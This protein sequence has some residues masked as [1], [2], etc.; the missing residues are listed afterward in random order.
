MTEQHIKRVISDINYLFSFSFTKMS[1]LICNNE[2]KTTFYQ[3]APIA[4]QLQAK[5]ETNQKKVIIQMQTALEEERVNVE[6]LQ[7]ALE[8]ERA[9]VQMLQTALEAEHSKNIQLQSIILADCELINE[10]QTKMENDEKLISDLQTK[11]NEEHTKICSICCENEITTSCYP[12]GHTYCY[13]C[14]ANAANCHI[15]RSYI[16]NINRI[17]I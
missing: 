6:M 9:N 14:I 7:F 4:V 1:K 16:N 15:C 12:C 10:C 11:V 5:L 3:H 8:A 13:S 2:K 17:Y